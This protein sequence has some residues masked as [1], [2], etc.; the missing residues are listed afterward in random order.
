MVATGRLGR[1]AGTSR[2]DALYAGLRSAG[3]GRD[4]VG[5]RR[6]ACEWRVQSE[7]NGESDGSARRGRRHRGPHRLGNLRLYLWPGARLGHPV[8][9]PGLLLRP[10]GTIGLSQ[11]APGR[12]PPGPALYRWLVALLCGH[13]GRQNTAAGADI[14]GRGTCLPPPPIVLPSPLR[15]GAGGGVR[16]EGIAHPDRRW[17]LLRLEPVQP[18]QH[19]PSPLTTDPAAARHPHRA[20]GATA[21]RG[22]ASAPLRGWRPDRLAGVWHAAHLSP[23]SGLFQRVGRPAQRLPRA[24]GL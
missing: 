11:Q 23:L 4:D 7:A 9:G 2:C 12:L 5:L 18:V 16:P 21:D 19:R 22:A 1:G 10:Q 20:A 14:V 17:L 6:P 8:A 24:G 15:G 3:A 13:T